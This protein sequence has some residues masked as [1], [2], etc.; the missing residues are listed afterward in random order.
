MTKIKENA[1][2]FTEPGLGAMLREMFVIGAE[3][4]SVMLRWAVRILSVHSEAQRK[5]QAEIDHVVGN[6]RD[7]MWS[8]L[9]ELHFT[10]AT[11]CEIQRFADIAPTA[12]GH[13]C[14]YDVDF[15]GF[16]LPKVYLVLLRILIPYINL[17]IKNPFST[18]LKSIFR[19]QVWW[20]I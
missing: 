14:M 13:K 7:V 6:D 16:H 12:V 1:E 4:E 3:S 11:L 8:D 17:C 10:R 2:Y 20:P 19:V 9:E 15:H 18:L 5:V